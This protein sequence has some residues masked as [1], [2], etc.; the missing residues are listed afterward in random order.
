[1]LAHFP[2]CSSS[3]RVK[4]GRLLSAVF[5]GWSLPS[6]RPIRFRTAWATCRAHTLGRR[7]GVSFLSTEPYKTRLIASYHILF[8]KSYKFFVCGI[9]TRIKSSCISVDVLH[10]RCWRNFWS[11]R[12]KKL[13]VSSVH[14]HCK[15]GWSSYIAC[16]LLLSRCKAVHRGHLLSKRL[17]S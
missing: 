16:V 5:A 2:R 4:G 14:N 10:T 1:M 11:P 7:T 8:P 15:S 3:L 6:S 13:N 17:Q 9:L 12:K